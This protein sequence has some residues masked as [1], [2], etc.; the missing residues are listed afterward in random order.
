MRKDLER[1][2]DILEA[3]AAIERHAVQDFDVFAGDE[4]VQIWYLKHIE[5]IGEASARLSSGIRERYPDI[6]WRDII[7]M[8]NMLIHSY[9]DIDWQ[10]VW[11]VAQRDLPIL[12]PQIAQIFATETE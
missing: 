8:R 5:I 10:A 7:G 9:F 11:Q 2:Q 4:M 1:L 3:C 6:P 12:K